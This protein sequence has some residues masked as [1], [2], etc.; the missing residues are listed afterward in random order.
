MDGFVK[1]GKVSDVRSGRGRQF[2]VNGVK[3]AVFRSAEGFVAV[4]DTCPHM[5]AS[6]T[7]GRLVDGAVECEW[8]HWR[9]DPATGVSDQRDWCSVDVYDVRVEGNDLLL[10][11]PSRSYD[12]AGR[13]EDR[14]DDED[15]LTWDVDR[16]FRKAAPDGGERDGDD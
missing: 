3:V 6:L 9:F 12:D 13:E 2:E 5:G 15:W 11:P 1:V 14:P 16:Y 4:S 8:H 10:R 7:N